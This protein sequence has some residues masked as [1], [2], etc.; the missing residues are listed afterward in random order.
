MT[1]TSDDLASARVSLADKV[2]FL[3]APESYARTPEQV[4]VVE[5]HMS[6]VFLAGERVYKLKKPVRFPFLDFSTLQLREAMCR[7]ELRLNRRL[8]ANVYLDV[9]P[10]TASQDGAL[11]IGGDGVVIDWLIEM[12]RLPAERM[13]DHALKQGPVSE[14]DIGL[15]ARRLARF[16]LGAD[17]S[18]ISA[19]DYA[20]R[21]LRE[22]KKN[23]EILT[24]RE[25]ALDHGRSASVL[26][27]LDA[28]LEAARALLEQRVRAG[29]IVDGH[30]DLRPEHICFCDDIVIFDCLEFNAELRQVDPFDELAFLGVEC[31]LLGAPAFGQK[32]LDAVSRSLDDPAPERLI[33]LYAASRAML[34]ARLALAHLLDPVPRTPDKWEPLASR[35]LALAE[36][37]MA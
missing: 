8:A 13:L 27:R 34:R 4:R 24:S 29:R 33:Q 3:S 2:R 19:G 15:L 26:D 6:F 16:Y 37:A 31:A 12:R 28:Q 14:I 9:R 32:L 21:F 20:D 36:A 35:Y 25:F 17:R 1:S 5:T 22:Q 18:T 30:G 7:E 11:K 10:L 23:R